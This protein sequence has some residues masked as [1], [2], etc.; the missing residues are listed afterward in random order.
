MTPP[1]LSKL[2]DVVL[3]VTDADKSYRRRNDAF[4]GRWRH[5]AIHANREVSISVHAGEIVAVIGQSGSGKSTLAK[6]VTGLETLDRGEVK[7]LG[8]GG[9][10]ASKGAITLKFKRPS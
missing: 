10:A 7:L 2:G 5:D 6:V 4:G 8:T 9:K 1:R 3:A